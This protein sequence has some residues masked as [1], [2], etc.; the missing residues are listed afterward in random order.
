MRPRDRVLAAINHRE[1]DH[2]PIDIG[3]TDVTGINIRAY[4]NLLGQLGKTP[5][6]D[7]PILDIVQQLAKPSEEML[8][9]LAAHCRCVFPAS[10][11][12]WKLQLHED[13]A[14]EWFIDEWGIQWRKP[15]P[16]GLYYDLAHQPLAGASLEQ[17][18][19]YP[20]PD[21]EDPARQVGLVETAK[22]IHSEGEYAVV[23]SG[24][25][26]GGPMEVSAWIAGFENF[27]IA[28]ASDPNWADALLDRILEIKLRFWQAIL[29]QVGPYVDIIAESE[30]LGTQDRLMISPRSF[31]L[32]IKPRLCQLITGI[33]K[34]APHIKVM[35]H[36]DGAIVPVLPDL[37]EIG[38]DILNPVQVSAKG[39]GDT[40]FLKREFGSDL[41]FWGAIDT[42]STL[43]LGTPQ[44][45]RD[46][47]QRRIQDLAAGG[48]YV[49]AS[50]HNIQGDVPPKN[51]LAMVEAWQQ[52][53]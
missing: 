23:L 44:D 21:P 26:G 31:Q 37:I 24:I 51:I 38:V 35:L 48:G 11:T 5:A 1:P 28:L 25:T 53:G 47:V 19:A 2:V 30:D 41:V 29:P 46:E 43:S 16:S 9:R 36:S 27:F 39:M 13:E 14:N 50:V 10:P 34:A 18:A 4:R 32:H 12:G 15:K 52:F 8:C 20:W 42:Q 49:L 40:A 7:L 22:G 6:S 33:K 17:I 3:G 45:V